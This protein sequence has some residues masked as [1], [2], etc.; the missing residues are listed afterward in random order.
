MLLANWNKYDHSDPKHR[1]NLIQALQFYVSLPNKFLNEEFL[2]S[3]SDK[4]REKFEQRHGIIQNALRFQSESGRMPT[5]VELR[6]FAAPGDFPAPI[7]D[8]IEKFH[9]VTNYDNGY[10]QIFDIH[11]AT[12]SK[13]SGFSISNVQ[14]GLTFE[15]MLPGEKVEVKQMSGTRVFV[16][17]H[18]YAGAL[19]WHKQLF[20]DEEWWTIEDNAIEFTNKAYARRAAVFYALLEA[21]MDAKTCITLQ[22]VGCNDCN[23]YYIAVARAINQAAVNILT[24]VQN[25]GYGVTTGTSFTVLTPLQQMD[26][27]RK[28][29]NKTIQS[30]QG[31]A[32]EVNFNF[33][34]LTTMMLTNTTR[35]G[36]ILPKVRLKGGYRMDLT[37][38]SNFDM[39]SYT[40]AA[41]GW[42]RYGGAIGDL[43]QIECVDMSGVS[44]LQGGP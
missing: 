15:Q 30:Y 4:D 43:D 11:D 21:A 44:G 32:L 8:I 12:T 3:L 17:Y 31:S 33:R 27:V 42:Q 16:F 37:T 41:A 25:K 14:S 38:F 5:P 40:E 10:E 23:E 28:A 6:E 20:D 26:A 18:Y 34:Q 39:L 7:I 35:I 36:V 22:D 9:A 13:K 29:L 24:A 19:G 2:E 1:K